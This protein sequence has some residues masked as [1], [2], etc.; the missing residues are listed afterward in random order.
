MFVKIT[1]GQVAAYPYTVGDL[2]RDNPNTSFAK[3]VPEA[4]MAEFGMFPVGYEAAPVF[5]P[6][7]HRIENSNL[8]V[9]KD[10]KWMLTKTVVALT[11]EQIANR[12]AAKAKE[13]RSQRDRLLAETDWIVIM[14]TEKGTNIPAAWEIY[15]QSLR[16]ITS[17]Q[18]FPY[19][20]NWPTKPE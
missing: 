3:H 12:D 11:A 20:I 13:V 18:G 6:M 15:R 2:R 1:N 9:L 14:H 5:D 10:G 16:D 4:V 19:T 17:Q 8:P 7:T